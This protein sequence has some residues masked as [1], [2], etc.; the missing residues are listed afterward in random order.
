MRYTPS[1]ARCLVLLGSALTQQVFLTNIFILGAPERW[2]VALDDRTDYPAFPEAELPGRR[3]LA[4]ERRGSLPEWCVRLQALPWPPVEH[5]HRLQP[6][7]FREGDHL[8]VIPPPPGG[9]VEHVKHPEEARALRGT[10]FQVLD[11]RPDDLAVDGDA[12]V[13]PQ[14]LLQVEL[15]RDLAPVVLLAGIVLVAVHG[16]TADVEL[17]LEPAEAPVAAVE[18]LSE[19]DFLA[20]GQR[21]LVLPHRLH[22]VD[23]QDAPLLLRGLAEEIEN[24]PLP[25]PPEPLPRRAARRGRRLLGLLVLVDAECRREVGPFLRARRGQQEAHREHAA[26]AARLD[27]LVRAVRVVRALQE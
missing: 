2:M 19:N 3:R 22:I 17:A 18:L 26:Q 13:R 16:A 9:D 6:E 11:P 20:Q 23:G 21:E 10:I 12:R 4:V 15:A 8:V 25:L 7:L 1:N 5:R 24:A 14:L 27:A